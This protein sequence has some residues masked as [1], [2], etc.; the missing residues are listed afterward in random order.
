MRSSD[1]LQMRSKYPRRYKRISNLRFEHL[2]K[3][4]MN[5]KESSVE[6][7]FILQRTY[8]INHNQHKEINLKENTAEENFILQRTYNI[9]YNQQK[10]IKLKENTVHTEPIISIKTNIKKSI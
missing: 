7:S 4:T 5:M 1:E 9:N 6:E 10:R 2:V 3:S 8:N